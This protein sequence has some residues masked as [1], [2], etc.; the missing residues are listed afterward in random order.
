MKPLS[1]RFP[2][3]PPAVASKLGYY[4]YLYV[5]PLD[6]TV[7]YVGKGQSGRALAHLRTHEEKAIT[8]IIE[9]IRAAGEEP[10]RRQVR[11]DAN[12]RSGCALHPTQGQYP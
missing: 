9:K 11:P 4:V 1:L 12:P 8:K 10:D 7:F 2:R 3:I 5:N 6:K